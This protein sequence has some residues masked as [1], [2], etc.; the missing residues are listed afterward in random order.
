[1]DDMRRPIILLL[2]WFLL[3]NFYS[4]KK[5]IPQST[6]FVE[7][8]IYEAI[9]DFADNCRLFKQDSIFYITTLD[10]LKHYTLQRNQGTLEWICDSIYANLFVINIIPSINKLFYLPDAV[11]GSKGKLPSRYVIVKSK[12]FY[13]DDDDYPLTEETLSV[14]KKYDALT[15]MIH[16]RVLPETVIS[17][18]KEI[19]FYYFC[20]NNL[21]KHKRAVSSKSAGYYRPPKLKC[22]N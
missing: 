11:V 22:G 3:V 6:N 9:T 18:S 7:F 17:D 20:R 1:M 13:W 2:L 15:D 19:A 5:Y 10:T 14:L 4:Q 21:L 8:A 12:L 16:D